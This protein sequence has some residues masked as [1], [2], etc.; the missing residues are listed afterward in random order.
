MKR[1]LS[2]LLASVLL[3]S[4]FSIGFTAFGAQTLTH[5][6]AEATIN[7]SNQ[8]NEIAVKVRSNE[9]IK[10]IVVYYYCVNTKTLK[11]SWKK[12]SSIKRITN[13]YMV[14]RDSYY[15]SEGCKYSY[16]VYAYNNKNKLI[17]TKPVY[18]Y[19][20]VAMSELSIAN[21]SRNNKNH[22][23]VVSFNDKNKYGYQ[24]PISAEYK[25][26]N[27]HNIVGASVS[28]SSK[29][30][31]AFT[32]KNSAIKKGAKFN[33]IIFRAR[34]KMPVVKYNSKTKKEYVSYQTVYSPWL[35]IKST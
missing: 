29:S 1:I 33:E 35:R 11:G 28:S 26:S 21:V 15:T 32:I 13:R 22:T 3:F 23:I 2:F 8:L 6:S 7:P 25:L 9:T 17:N 20:N 27:K 19:A 31:Y 12:L 18:C 4:M 16:K 34:Y 5:V 14:A 10:K 30:K 24:M